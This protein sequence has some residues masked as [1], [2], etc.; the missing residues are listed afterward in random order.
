MVVF[1][2]NKRMV[3]ITKAFIT[4]LPNMISESTAF[5]EEYRNDIAINLLD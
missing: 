1:E 4:V 5:Y 2:L 3:E